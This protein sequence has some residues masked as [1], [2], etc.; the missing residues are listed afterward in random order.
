MISYPKKVYIWNAYRCQENEIARCA[1][2]FYRRM[3]TVCSGLGFRNRSRFYALR[4][5][6]SPKRLCKE[7]G[8]I[9]SHSII[10]LLA[11]TTNANIAWSA[12]TPHPGMSFEQDRPMNTSAEQDF[13]QQPLMPEQRMI[14]DAVRPYAAD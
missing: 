12:A 1:P 5:V 10:V 2:L 9:Y 7:N 13:F 11:S 8:G 4:T 14:Q 6:V 3:L